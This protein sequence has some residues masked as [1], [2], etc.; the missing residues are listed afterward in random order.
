MIKGISEIRRIP[1]L[2]H[3]RL[4]IK[5]TSQKG[6][7][8]PSEVDYFILDPNTGDAKWNAEL[9]EQFKS[10]YGEKP[11]AI[12]I[13]F[14]PAAPEIFFAQFFKRYGKSTLLQCK[15]DGE[16]AITT[17]EFAKG[18]EKIGEDERGF[19]QVKC[20]GPECPYQLGN[21]EFCPKAPQCARMAA[22][23]VILPDIKGLGIWQIATGSYNSIVNINSALD[24]LKGLTGR[25]A[26]LPVTLMRVPTE[27]AYEGKKSKHY[28]LQIDTKD[29]SIG[30][31]QKFASLK[32]IQ[33]ALI[34]G[35]DESKDT[36]FY[37]KNGLKP[38]LE[39]PEEPVVAIPVKESVPE[40]KPGPVA[41]SL[42]GDFKKETAKREKSKAIMDR[43]YEEMKALAE[44]E[45][46]DPSERKNNLLEFTRSLKDMGEMAE[47]IKDHKDE[48]RDK[49]MKLIDALQR[50]IDKETKQMI[51]GKV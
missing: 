8:Y 39:A 12:K 34:P 27:I 24:W 45:L 37:D 7:E 32:S 22:L 20:L 11:K 21:N 38:A 40:V 48:L 25:F 50:E 2:G 15:G 46:V 16:I 47:L 28:I 5:K 13:M 23:Q 31:I 1:R 4:G 51:D 10:L 36:L 9:K 43:M 49:Y 35:P 26:M 19:W 30:D 6:V 29:V 33:T 14:P 3:I 41:P 44:A 17:E 42:K 18:L